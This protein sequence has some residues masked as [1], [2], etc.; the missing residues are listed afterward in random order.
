MKL[1]ALGLLLSDV[2]WRRRHG[3]QADAIAEP[4]D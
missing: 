2:S 1:E 3:F 4:D